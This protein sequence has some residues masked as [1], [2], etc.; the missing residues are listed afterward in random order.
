MRSCVLQSR[1]RSNLQVNVLAARVTPKVV[2]F[3]PN[4][5]VQLRPELGA[6][7]ATDSGQATVFRQT[8]AVNDIGNADSS[9]TP[10]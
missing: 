8:A 4:K 5:G 10:R 7:A 2:D 3:R 1:S 6:K 9:S